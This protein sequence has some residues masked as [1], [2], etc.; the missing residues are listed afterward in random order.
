MSTANSGEPTLSGAHPVEI[1]D[2]VAIASR[3]GVDLQG[4]L[5]RGTSWG[6][7][8]TCL[9]VPAWDLLVDL[10]AVSHRHTYASTVLIT[11]GHLD[12]IG[13]LAN[14]IALRQMMGQPPARYILAPEILQ[15][16]ENLLEA[17]R[18]LDCAPLDAELLPLESGH[19]LPLRRD[20]TITPFATRH[21]VKSQGYVLHSRVQK[22]NED[23]QG[24]PSKRIAELRRSGAEVTHT[25]R[26]SEIAFSGDTTIEG[27]LPYPEVMGA[28]RLVMECTFLDERV[29]QEKAH[30]LGHVHLDDIAEHADAFACETLVLTHLSLRYTLRGAAGLV[31]DRLPGHLADRVILF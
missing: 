15:P 9:E 2:G 5:M 31:R 19:S 23:L 24:L 8:R 17:C 20:L 12:H 7:V 1:V 16:I 3:Q 28:K 21:R 18:V 10:G 6:G 30:R 27:L 13:G 26:V 11:H 4:L 25:Q 14:H 22:L 29:P